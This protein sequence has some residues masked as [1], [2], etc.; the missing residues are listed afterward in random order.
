M[1]TLERIYVII[2]MVMLMPVLVSAQ[3][4]GTIKGKII[5]QT[6]KEPI[7]GVSIALKEMQLT[8][9]SDS[10]GLFSINDIAVGTYSLTLSYVGFQEKLLNDITVVPGKTYYLEAELLNDDRRLSAVTVKAFRG[11]HNPMIPV[12]SYSFSREEIF[13]SPGAQGDI[14]RAI[15]ILPGVVSSGGQYSA[16]AVRG[17][18]TSDNVYIADD[19]PLFE[20][21]HLEVEG[22]NAGFNDPNGGR[23]SIFAPRVID[24]ALFEGGGFG[25]QYGRR[26]SSYLG[27]GIKEGNKETP[28]LSGQFDLL[29]ATLIYDGPSGFDKKTSVFASARYQ[30]FALVEQLIGYN[31]V[32]TP[33]YGDYMIKTTTEINARNKLSLIAMLNPESYTRTI[34]DFSKSP[35]LNKDNSSNF[36]GTSKTGKAVIG[37]SL[38]TLTGKGSYWK[39]VLYFRNKHVD[40]DL[41]I[42]NPLVD[43]GGNIVD[44]ISIPYESDLRHIKDDQHEFGYRSIFTVHGKHVHM[45]AGIDL[46]RMDLDY[47]RTLK[48]TD[49][50]YT[51]GPNDYRPV[52][53]Q[54]YLILQPSDFNSMYKDFA[55][56]A[57]GYVDLS[58]TLFNWLTL[59]PGVR[60]DYTGFAKQH[61]VAPRI[62]GSIGIDSRQSVNFATGVYYEDP[63]YSDIASQPAGHNLKSERTIQYILG[64]KYYFS[65]DLKLTAEGWYKQFDD[66]AVQPAS[67]RPFLNNNGTGYAYGGDI[68]LTKRL[69]D[70]YYGQI[71]YSYMLSKRDDHG[72]LGK[73][74]YIF[75]IPHSFSLLGSY[76]PNGKWVFS[77]KFR[78][79]TG[80][81]TDNYIV[82]SNVFHDSSY[83]RYAQQKIGKNAGR[84]NN[85]ISLD[86]R[87]D[88]K[89]TVKKASWTA[90]VDIV[91][92]NNRFN[93]SS[94]I[95]QTL[96]GR[97]YYLGLAVFPSF[98]LRVDW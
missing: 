42:A 29:G 3:Q 91:D 95:F 6:T 84:L 41:G 2:F 21:S 38:R 64:Y 14:F 92:V 63:Q 4:R 86:L 50:L 16:I 74:D 48:H 60:Y 68:N 71:G 26:S 81:P 45:T 43:A 25:A 89:W 19:I 61:M 65:P 82:H 70:N 15:G 30:N 72:G 90:F 27:L 10:A 51:F 9:V 87:A 1:S 77:G 59:N 93:Q 49:T 46:A 79:S 62:S 83:L 76:K 78:Y 5:A 52:A 66:V 44:K 73:Y 56:N 85:F 8:V 22:F 33:A 75:S 24:N 58:F 28:F 94:G 47:A 88:Y 31:S 37:L 23:F 69:S 39:N 12:S 53:S 11:E 17:Q 18:G 36:I 97:V 57:S 54:Y 34:N 7:S 35:S 40:N 55:Y 67:G 20:V 32:G 80:R 96:T 13:R 98:G